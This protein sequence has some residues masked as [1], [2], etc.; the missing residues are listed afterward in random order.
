MKRLVHAPL[1]DKDIE[2]ADTEELYKR[3]A[4]L[5]VQRGSHEDRFRWIAENEN[6]VCDSCEANNEKCHAP[7]SSG[8]IPRIS[9]ENCHRSQKLLAPCSRVR[10]E[11]KSR[12]MRKLDI[13]ESMYDSLSERYYQKSKPKTSR[14]AAANSDP[15]L[16]FDTGSEHEHRGNHEPDR[17]S[18]LS[19]C[20][21]VVEGGH[22]E[23][24]DKL[25]ANAEADHNIRFSESLESNQR[26]IERSHEHYCKQ[27][28]LFQENIETIEEDIRTGRR[29][30]E[31]AATRIQELAWEVGD[32]A[33]K[34]LN[35]NRDLRGL[36]MEDVLGMMTN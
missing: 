2:A 32:F 18:P 8:S 11:R 27:M 7:A 24:R 17:S 21:S 22:A 6:L 30:V 4:E 14:W 28:S 10:A 3:F 26:I 36:A 13:T 34:C 35:V 23:L 16:L 20:V 29:S 1:Q 12:I 33:Q 15:A 5:C 25:M 9:C 31:S 19:P